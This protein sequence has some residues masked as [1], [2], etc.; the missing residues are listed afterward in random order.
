MYTILKVPTVA[1]LLGMSEQA[2]RELIKRK[3]WD[4]GSV[5]QSGKKRNY[6]IYRGRLET[7][8]GRT[9]TDE[10]IQEAEGK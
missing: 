1:R 7:Q 8:V 2:V 10:E 9:F 5:Y 3:V 4:C 6:I